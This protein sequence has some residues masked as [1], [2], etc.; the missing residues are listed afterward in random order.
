MRGVAYTRAIRDTSA[1]KLGQ[2]YYLLH[3][4]KVVQLV[5]ALTVGA[6]RRLHQQTGVG[7]L[8][9]QKKNKD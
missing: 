4:S 2:L 5:D 3:S 9:R 1:H 7:K 6:I 8:Q